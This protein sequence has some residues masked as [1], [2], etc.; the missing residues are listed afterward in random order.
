MGGWGENISKEKLHDQEGK[1]ISRKTKK[2]FIKMYNIHHFYCLTYCLANLLPGLLEKL[3]YEIVY[4]F[5]V[6]NIVETAMME[7]AMVAFPIL[8]IYLFSEGE[9]DLVLTH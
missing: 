9:F 4:F 8:V 6:P 3:K 5:P 2:V 7:T 1:E